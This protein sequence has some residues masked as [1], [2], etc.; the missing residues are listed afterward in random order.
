MNG[1][2]ERTAHER[3]EAEASLER[4]QGLDAS[5]RAILGLEASIESLRLSME[6][7]RVEMDG[8]YN[9]SLAFEDKLNALQADV[10][11]WNT[12]KNRIHHALPKVREFV[13]RATWASGAPERKRLGELHK[14]HIEPRVP[15]PKMDQE[16]EQ[17]EHLLKDRQLLLAQGNAVNQDCRGILADI[18]RALSTLQRN[19]ADNARRKMARR[20]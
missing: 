7:L 11:Q 20:P 19:A 9:R 8:A 6:S 1:P 14:N 17:M 15:F 16:R 12:A 4:W 13:H 18:Q 2:E 10:A 3:R 5:W